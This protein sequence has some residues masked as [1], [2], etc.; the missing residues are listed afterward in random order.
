MK[1]SGQAEWDKTKYDPFK[2]LAR[3]LAMAK[4]RAKL[5]DLEFNIDK[6]YLYSL[7]IIQE[8]KCTISKVEMDITQPLNGLPRWNAP[9][10]DRI[11]PSKGYTK[12]NV[13]IV[14]Y[15]INAAMQDYGSEHF[16]KLCKIVVGNN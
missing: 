15:Q 3:L 10:I 14:C 9:S 11:E 7:W 5:K 1:F 16:I 4:N 12:G 13:R 6:D 2:R 8:G